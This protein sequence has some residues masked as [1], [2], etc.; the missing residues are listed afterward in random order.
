VAGKIQNRYSDIV[1]ELD[2][3]DYTP[4]YRITDDVV[5]VVILHEHCEGER[6]GIG[7]TSIGVL[8]A[9]DIGS[10]LV[11]PR[12]GA[13]Q[14]TIYVQSRISVAVPAGKLLFLVDRVQGS[15][16]G[17]LGR[18]LFAGLHGPANM[19]SIDAQLTYPKLHFDEGREVAWV[20]PAGSNLIAADALNVFAI[21]QP[22]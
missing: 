17:S 3:T 19:Q 21:F 20:I 14:L 8:A 1:R 6:V 10:V 22:V 15:A 11:L 12:P 5:P 7:G 4:N 13:Y 9:G 16:A 18:T 2:I